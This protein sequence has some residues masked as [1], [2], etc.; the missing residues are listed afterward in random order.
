MLIQVDPSYEQFV[1][2]E[3]GKPVI[4]TELDKALYGTLQAALLFWQDLSGY[5]IKELGFEP[6]PYD[7]CVVNKII[8]GKQMT[9]GWHVDDLKM[10]HVSQAILE[11]VISKLELRYGKEAPLSITRGDIH[12][13]LGMKIDFSEKGKVKFSMP[14]YIDR[15][16]EDTPDE[17]LKGPASTPAADHLFQVNP[18][19]EKLDTSSAI[20]F[21]H[22]TAQLLYLGK[23]TRPDVFTAVSFLCT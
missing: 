7:P 2:E 9:I 8:K 12:E 16:I 6:N 20:I 19:A 21:H 3:K 5:L 10:S 15:M 11:D 22:L 13:Y 18:D 1:V 4:Y 14:E 17:L 23:R